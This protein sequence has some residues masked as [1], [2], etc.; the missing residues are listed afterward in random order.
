MAEAALARGG[1]GDECG[2]CG[3]GEHESPLVWEGQL[4]PNQKPASAA[5]QLE[6]DHVTTACTPDAGLPGADVLAH[7]PQLVSELKLEADFI[8]KRVAPDGVT[9][10]DCPPADPDTLNPSALLSCLLSGK[11]RRAGTRSLIRAFNAAK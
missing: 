5:N 2:A 9:P 10:V 1:R 11:G 6:S 3:T 4:G 7:L 8:Y